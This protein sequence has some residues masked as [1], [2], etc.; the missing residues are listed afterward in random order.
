MKTFTFIITLMLLGSCGSA[1]HLIVRDAW[2]EVSLGG[3]RG[4]RAE[5]F[6]IIAKENEI[7]RPLYLLVGEVKIELSTS[8]ENGH[9]IL[10]GA[11]FTENQPTVTENGIIDPK[12]ILFD[13][14]AAYLIS[15][16]IQS[17]K[18]IRQKVSFKNK[19]KRSSST[20]PQDVPQ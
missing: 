3:V 18:Q 17:R 9:M 5:R 4:A 11:Y 20:L 10:S 16:N 12:K 13:V 15:E 14:G 1:Q 19:Q 8:V 7:F 6:T 2:H